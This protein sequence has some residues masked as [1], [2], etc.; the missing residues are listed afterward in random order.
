M[1]ETALAIPA[2]KR[3]AR[4]GRP[5]GVRRVVKDK[6]ILKELLERNCPRHDAAKAKGSSGLPV[7]RYFEAGPLSDA[8]DHHSMPAFVPER[9]REFVEQGADHLAWYAFSYAVWRDLILENSDLG[10]FET[11]D[12]IE[13]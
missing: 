11:T 13:T 10:L 7:S 5:T 3:Y 6:Y 1:L 12:V 9:K 2:V 4:F 8:F